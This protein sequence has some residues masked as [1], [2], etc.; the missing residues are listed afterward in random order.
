MN[1]H[2]RYPRDR[3]TAYRQHASKGPGLSRRVTT[4]LVCTTVQRNHTFSC[5]EHYIQV[6]CPKFKVHHTASP[7]GHPCSQARVNLVGGGMASGHARLGTYTGIPCIYP[8][9]G[10]TGSR[11]NDNRRVSISSC[12]HLVVDRILACVTIRRLFLLMS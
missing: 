4:L 1:A 6:L 10:R 8:R 11:A 2:T 3:R 7:S 5:R 9:G 12:I